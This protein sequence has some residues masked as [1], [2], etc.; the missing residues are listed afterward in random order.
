MNMALADEQA[1]TIDADA[2]VY[3][4]QIVLLKRVY[5]LP[6]A[7]FLFAEGTSDEARAAFSTHDVFIK[8]TALDSLLADFAAQR[9]TVLRE[10]ARADKFTASAEPRITQLQVRRA[11]P[12]VSE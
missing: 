10:P 6:W 9:I 12:D 4:L 3:G 11:G 5:V 8:G 1:W 7:Q 2:R